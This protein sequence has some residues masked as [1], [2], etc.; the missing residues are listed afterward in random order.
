MEEKATLQRRAEIKEAKIAAINRLI[1][2]KSSEE[3]VEGDLSSL[4]AR[5]LISKNRALKNKVNKYNQFLREVRE[6]QQALQPFVEVI[7]NK[8]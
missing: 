3:D 8:E 5:D 2:H 1:A 6:E 4:E 7:E